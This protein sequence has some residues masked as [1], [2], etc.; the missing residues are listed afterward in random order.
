MAV[1]DPIGPYGGKRQYPVR[2]EIEIYLKGIKV[3]SQ[4][5]E[6]KTFDLV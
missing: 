1:A 2:G 3:M 6:K 4:V 5:V